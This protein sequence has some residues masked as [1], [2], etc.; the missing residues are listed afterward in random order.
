MAINRH[1]PYISPIC[2]MPDIA[3]YDTFARG[4][5]L[6]SSN[7]ISTPLP[8]PLWNFF[9]RSNSAFRVPGLRFQESSTYNLISVQRYARYY[10]QYPSILTESFEGP[11]YYSLTQT[12]SIC[13]PCTGIYCKGRVIGRASNGNICGTCSPR[14]KFARSETSQKP[15]SPPSPAT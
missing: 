13:H 3:V 12:D 10:Y 1:V 9:L 14:Q 4:A 11:W 6:Q 2:R 5:P 8:V 7:D 15:I